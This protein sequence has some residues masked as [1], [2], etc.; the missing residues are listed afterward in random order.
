MRRYP[1]IFDM[2]MSP[3]FHMKTGWDSNVVTSFWNLLG[4]R[5]LNTQP[6]FICAICGEPIKIRN[7]KRNL[8]CKRHLRQYLN[9]VQAGTRKAVVHKRLV[10]VQ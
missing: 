10:A 2:H 3:V 5:A 9:E 6:K 7:H 4:A 1:N 8:I